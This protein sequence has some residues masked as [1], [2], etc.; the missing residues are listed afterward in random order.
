[1]DQQGNP[2]AAAAGAGAG[3]SDS[4]AADHFGKPR[5]FGTCRPCGRRFVMV[6][7]GENCK[8][9]TGCIDFGCCGRCCALLTHGRNYVMRQDNQEWKYML[10]CYLCGD[11]VTVAMGD[12]YKYHIGEGPSYQAGKDHLFCGTCVEMRSDRAVRAASSPLSSSNWL[13]LLCGT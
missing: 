5:M 6:E 4:S 12:R 3:S 9:I 7:Q 1:M 2:A 10:P 13:W 8:L 11:D